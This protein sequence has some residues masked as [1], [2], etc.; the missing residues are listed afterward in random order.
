[1]QGRFVIINPAA[2][3]MAGPVP[4]DLEPDKWQQHF[5]VL[6]D[7]Q[8]TPLPV[9]QFPLFR[10]IR[11]D[12]VSESEYFLKNLACPQGLWVSASASP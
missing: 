6:Q 7:D 12:R 2:R 8:V 5:G 4:P 1:M 9:E 11:G 3:K 10:A